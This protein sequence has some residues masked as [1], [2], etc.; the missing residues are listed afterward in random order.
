MNHVYPRILDPFPLLLSYDPFGGSRILG[1]ISSSFH[2]SLL[3]TPLNQGF[4][5][6]TE[7]DRMK[8]KGK[9]LRDRQWILVPFPFLLPA[10]PLASMGFLS[11]I[12]SYGFPSELKGK[13]S[14]REKER[15]IGG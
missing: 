4:K 12:F 10:G 11:F 1:S 13:P 14:K 5:G 15:N 6:A 3:G 9:W 2:S 7:E 8:G